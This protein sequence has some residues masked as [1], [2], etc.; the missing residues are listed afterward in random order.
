MLVKFKIKTTELEYQVRPEEMANWEDVKYSVK[1]NDFDGV[2]RSFTSS[3]KFVG[4]ARD[5]II[6]EFDKNYLRAK[7][8]VV[9]QSMNNN[10]EYHDLFSC[11]LDFSTLQYDSTTATIN[12]I[13]S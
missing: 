9:V 1:R 4:K 5:V 3:F 10:L 6:S 2:V 12:S 7:A 8:S 11:D 13:A